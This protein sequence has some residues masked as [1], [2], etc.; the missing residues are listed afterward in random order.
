[1]KNPTI[2]FLERLDAMEPRLRNHANAQRSAICRAG[3]ADRRA[4]D[5]TGLAHLGE[6]RPTGQQ[7]H[8]VVGNWRGEPFNLDGSSRYPTASPSSSVDRGLPPDELMDQV[9]AGH[10]RDR[11]FLINLPAG[12]LGSRWPPPI[13]R[14]HAPRT[15]RRR[16]Y[17]GPP[18]RARQPARRSGETARGVNFSGGLANLSGSRGHYPRPGERCPRPGAPGSLRSLGADD[19]RENRALGKAWE[20]VKVRRGARE[21][22]KGDRRSYRNFDRLDSVQRVPRSHPPLPPRSWP[23]PAAP[24]IPAVRASRRALYSTA[25]SGGSAC[26]AKTNTSTARRRVSR[27]L[28]SIQPKHIASSIASPMSTRGFPVNSFT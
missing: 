23:D 13:P 11:S 10:R 4:A 20:G 5:R 9:S 28:L 17:G 1:M 2:D 12:R 7:A 22:G 15:H 14:R 16:V 25:T 6:S 24:I 27:D 26:A 8:H 3:R 18:G 19:P 21:L